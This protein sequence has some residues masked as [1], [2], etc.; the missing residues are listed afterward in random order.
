MTL[1]NVA[2]A[3]GRNASTISRAILHKHL[4]FPGGLIPMQDLL[5]HKQSPANKFAK[6]EKI[7]QWVQ[8]ENKGEPLSD[9]A[10]AKKLQIIGIACARRTV[11]KYRHSLNIPSVPFRA[12]NQSTYQKLDP[13]DR[14]P[15][16][17]PY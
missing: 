6:E 10:L 3:L 8:E 17:S 13:A 7:A 14:K 12:Q 5:R 15:F 1:N 9:E 4:A 16:R 11:A 2:E